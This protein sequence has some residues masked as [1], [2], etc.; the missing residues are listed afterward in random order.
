MLQCEQCEFF[1]RDEA[2]GRIMLR[3]DPFCTIKEPQ[4]LEKWQLLRLDALVQSYQATLRLHEKLAPMQKKMFDFLRRE[5]DDIDE[6]DSWKRPEDD[7][8]DNGPDDQDDP[9]Q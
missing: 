6:S 8:D 7:D 5:M 1:S 9:D 4:C 3:C 2:T